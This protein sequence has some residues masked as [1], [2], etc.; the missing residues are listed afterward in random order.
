MVGLGRQLPLL[1]TIMELDNVCIELP[2]LVE[3]AKRF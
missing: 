1:D 3:L 2:S